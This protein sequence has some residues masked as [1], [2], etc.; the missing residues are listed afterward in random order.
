M[1]RLQ[2][3]P[4]IGHVRGVLKQVPTKLE[5]F[6][7]DYYGEAI[8]RINKL[9]GGFSQLAMDVLLFVSRARRPLQAAELQHALAVVPGQTSAAEHE[10]YLTPME[11]LI[12]HCAGLAEI[13][14]QRVVRLTHP[15][16]QEYLDKLSERWFPEA[17]VNI[18]RTCLTYLCFDVFDKINKDLQELKIR[19]QRFPFLDYA[20]LHWA[21]HLKGKPE[22][23]LQ[24]LTLNFL[25]SDSIFFNVSRHNASGY[26]PRYVF[27]PPR[28]VFGPPRY[29]FGPPRYVFGPPRYVFG[30]TGLHVAATF[31]LDFTVGLLLG[32]EGVDVEFKDT[33]YG[34][35]P[36]SWAAMAGH[37]PVAKLLIERGGAGIDSKDKR[38]R[39]ALLLAAK[40]GHEAVVKLLIESGADVD[41]KADNG[42]T[43]LLLAAKR[44]CEAV[45]K[46]LV[47]KCGVDANYKDQFSRTPLSWAAVNGH[48]GV[49]KLLVENGGDVN[50]KDRVGQTPLSL[51][52]EEG[53]LDVVKLII[54]KGNAEVDSTDRALRTPLSRA[55]ENGHLE[56][57]K[58]L[59]E[60]GGASVDFKDYSGR[61]PLSWA[62][63]RGDE[64]V[65][66][67]LV[68][69]GGADVDS[70]DANRQTPLWWAVDGGHLNVVKLLVEKE[71]V[72]INSEIDG[73]LTPLLWAI[74][75]GQ[76]A[77]VEQLLAHGGYED[78]ER[79]LQL[80]CM[81]G[82][83]AIVDHLLRFG[84]NP[85]KADEHGWT[86]LLC[87]SH[88]RRVIIL[89]RLI[90][91]GAGEHPFSQIKVQPPTSWSETDKSIHL[92]LDGDGL[93]ARYR[94]KLTL[95]YTV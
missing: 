29:V 2:E 65:V 66:K 87:A 41:S 72:H 68:E 93:C 28:Y 59:V 23:V 63:E 49:T 69:G 39:T 30:M 40:R 3:Q 48:A 37:E 53:Y 44:G 94:G 42:E 70:K 76:E 81:K 64:S 27:G 25:C 77:V 84:A 83:V 88:F 78:F 18:A 14:S 95:H 38:G 1:N 55:A 13:D 46:L 16:V 31:G 80:G 34:R 8:G 67:L 24:E 6:Y 5:D 92:Q 79:E 11:P 7:D 86:S 57:V 10:S 52:A 15:T 4:S 73:G 74:E 20:A 89:D 9:P 32:R 45:V 21:S 58:L 56:I 47:E 82:H 60:K 19:R 61:T 50:L 62:A 90:S 17:E 85:N 36:L 35:T 26:P 51:A 12:G 54:E 71:G 22:K 91:A 75:T 33:G 43:P